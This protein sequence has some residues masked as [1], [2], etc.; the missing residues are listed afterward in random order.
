MGNR[1][2]GRRCFLILLFFAAGWL[3]CQ[4]SSGSRASPLT[5]PAANPSVPLAVL[6]PPVAS[7][8]PQESKPL[9]GP[10]GIEEIRDELSLAALVEEVLARNP[11]LAQMTAAWEAA[12]ERN[13]PVPSLTDPY[14]W[15]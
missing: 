2:R 9:P 8:P 10:K 14:F 1:F 13:P 6:Q 11:S 15:A 12:Y 4:T 7:I 3:L 5:Q